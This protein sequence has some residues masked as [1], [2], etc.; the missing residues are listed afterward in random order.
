MSWVR[1]QR[2]RV[3]AELIIKIV[4]A[5]IN[6]ILIQHISNPSTSILLKIDIATD[7]DVLMVSIM[8]YELLEGNGVCL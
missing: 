1:P 7:I 5:K 2:R 3:F 4:E 6:T 8:G